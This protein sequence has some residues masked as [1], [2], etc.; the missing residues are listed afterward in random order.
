[1]RTDPCSR[2]PTGSRPGAS[3]KGDASPT[4]RLTDNTTGTFERQVTFR[5]DHQLPED[6][7]LIRYRSIGFLQKLRLAVVHGHRPED[8]YRRKLTGKEGE[9]V[10]VLAAA[11]R[12][13]VR[14]VAR[15]FPSSRCASASRLDECSDD[16]D[17][18][19][20]SRRPQ[21]QIVISDGATGCGVR[22]ERN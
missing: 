7:E 2:F 12:Q 21:V 16:D 4:W 19:Q 5:S 20:I 13:S 18:K 9:A 14:I 15:C 10:V 22:L 1:M 6:R 11:E 3:T 17:A 8:V